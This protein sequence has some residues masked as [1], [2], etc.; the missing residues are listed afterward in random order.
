MFSIESIKNLFIGWAFF[1]QL[2]LILHFALRRWRFDLAIHYG[3]L[4]YGLGIPAAAISLLIMWAGEAWY[5]WLGGLFCRA[6]GAFGYEVEYI[7]KIQWRDPI[8]WQI[9][10]P[11]IML[12]L[13]TIMFYWWPL[14]LISKPL[15]YAYA[16]LFIISTVL[17]LASHKKPEPQEFQHTTGSHG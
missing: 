14:G 10:G 7:K 6:W 15:W 3:P 1:F 17:N 2:V 12:Y 13:A 4:V 16:V 5:F 11:Y 8:K 9:F